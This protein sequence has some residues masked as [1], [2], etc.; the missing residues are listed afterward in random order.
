MFTDKDVAEVGAAVGALNFR[1]YAVWVWEA[2]DCA[3]D[4]LIKAWPSTV[5]FKLILGTVK[6]CAAPF[7]HV[8]AFAPKRVIFACKGHL[9]AFVYDDLF[10]FRT[11]FL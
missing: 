6:F 5:S 10:L 4:F 7:A 8:G 3:W 9:G 2:F 11:K 1:A